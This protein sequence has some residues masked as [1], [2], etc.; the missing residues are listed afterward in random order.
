MTRLVALV[1]PGCKTPF[2]PTH[3]ERACVFACLHCPTAVE[4]TRASLQA[5][6]VHAATGEATAGL[7]WAL[8]GHMTVNRF[9]ASEPAAT[10]LGTV[11]HKG[12]TLKFAFDV[13]I[14]DLGIALAL[15]STAQRATTPL[16]PAPWTP[17]PAR[18]PRQGSLGRADAERIAHQVWVKLITRADGSIHQLDVSIGVTACV[19]LRVD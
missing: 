17:D 9:A 3:L 4:V 6:P 2:E 11:S 12:Q 1:C 8:A 18:E 13:P 15:T 19:V 7:Y 14:S 10:P 5:Y 16:V